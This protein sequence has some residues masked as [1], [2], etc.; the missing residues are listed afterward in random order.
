MIK[1]L[2][3]SIMACIVLTTVLATLPRATGVQT[4]RTVVTIVD[5]DNSLDASSDDSY[6]MSGIDNEITS[7]TI[8]KP[9]VLK[10]AFMMQLFLN[11]CSTLKISDP[12]NPFFA[13]LFHAAIE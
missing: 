8:H 11:I 13:Y 4:V 12:T 2:V 10:N 6:H 9:G 7:F 1:K 3:V 5:D